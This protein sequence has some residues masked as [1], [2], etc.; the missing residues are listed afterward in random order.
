MV[1]STLKLPNCCGDASPKKIRH[2]SPSQTPKSPSELK[3]PDMSPKSEKRKPSPKKSSENLKLPNCTNNN[4]NNNN[5]NNSH[6]KKPFSDVVI[7]IMDKRREVVTSLGSSHIA[8]RDPPKLPKC[9]QNL[10]VVPDTEQ[11]S[12]VLA[13]RDV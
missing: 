1:E 9:D 10:L 3:L 11:R 4:N 6:N 7:K 5:N 12:P 2:P 8:N 13:R